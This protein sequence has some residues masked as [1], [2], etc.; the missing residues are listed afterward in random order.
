MLLINNL[1]KR[2]GGLLFDR[3]LRGAAYL[4]RLHPRAN[5][6]RHGLEVVRDLPY[7]PTG[8]IEHNLDLY[9]PVAPLPEKE[10]GD[11][12]PYG[13]PHPVVLYLHGGA[14]RIL[15]KD[16]HWVMG[17]AFARR[18]FHV[19]NANYRLA[20]RHPFPAALE[21]ACAALEFTVREAVRNGGDPTRLIIAGESAGANLALTLALLTTVRR[22]EPWA[23]RVYDL[24]IVPRVVVPMCGILQVSDTARF[25]RRRVLPRWLQDRLVE[26]SDAYL[27]GGSS[28]S[29]DST[30]LADPLVILEQLA[31]ARTETSRPLPAIC[32]T[33][34][35]RDPLLDDTRRLEQALQ[36]LE[37]PHL[38]RYYPGEVHAFQALVYRE[39]AKRCW[40][41]TYAFLDHHLR[42]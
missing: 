10:R 4:G 5:P 37:V 31:D 26:T 32:A 24:G 2:V 20:P 6:H 9:R 8:L 3:G 16:T 33:V 34:G 21:D 25:A 23:A 7:L 18:G 35:T 41:D 13:A 27:A 14:F 12:Q 38:V 1:R 29:G 42:R 15:S 36:R 22:P 19:Y 17:L 39:S 40:Q 11:W 28:G 30:L